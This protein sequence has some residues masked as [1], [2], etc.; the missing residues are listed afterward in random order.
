MDE[1]AAATPRDF[2][3]TPYERSVLNNAQ[4][5]FAGIFPKEPESTRRKS[6]RKAAAPPAIP[7]SAVDETDPRLLLICMTPRSGS[8]ALAAVLARSGQLGQGG[9]RLNRNG[10]LAAIAA[11]HKPATM[12]ALLDHVILQGRTANGQS[13]IKCDLQQVLPFLLDPACFRLLRNA[14]LVYLTR[15]DVLAQAIS[16]YRG[17][18]AGIWH[19]NTEAGRSGAEAA[20]DFAGISSQVAFITNMMQGYERTFAML[21]MQPLRI[22]Y[23]ALVADP[24]TVLARIAA[25]TGVNLPPGLTLQDSGFHPVS[26]D[27]NDSLRQQYLDDCH[28]R[29]GLA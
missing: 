27:N 26:D 13:Q 7:P 17:F 23:E 19:S 11:E 24:G 6:A 12:R 3:P 8:S 20:Y 18:A 25:L 10:A 9:E 15:E 5:W 14:R 4:K 1:A 29:L 21:A 16:R 22:T 28:R 2:Y